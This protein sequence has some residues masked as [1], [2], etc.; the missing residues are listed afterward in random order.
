MESGEKEQRAP[1]EGTSMEQLNFLHDQGMREQEMYWSRFYSFAT[2][3]AGAFLLA[4]AAPIGK[5]LSAVLGLALAVAWVVTQVVGVGY[6]NRTKLVYHEKRRE[7]G[8][9][10]KYGGGKSEKDDP[11]N[12]PGLLKYRHLSAS[13]IGVWVS[14]AVLLFWIFWTAAVIFGRIE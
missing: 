7:L 9:Y 11:E 5:L 3:S 13:S 1:Q 8:F 14:L 2:L 12:P 6:V 4:T 10:Y